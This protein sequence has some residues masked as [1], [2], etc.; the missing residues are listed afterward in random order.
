MSGNTSTTTTTSTGLVS[1]FG[2]AV[3]GALPPA[4]ILLILLNAGFMVAYQWNSAEEAK[5]KAELIQTLI[6]ACLIHKE[7]PKK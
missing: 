3:V 4:F 6:S 2:L 5:S 7:G 1:Q